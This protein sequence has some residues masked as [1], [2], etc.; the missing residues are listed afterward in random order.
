MIETPSNVVLSG[1]PWAERAWTFQEN[2]FSADRF[3]FAAGRVFYI[4]LGGTRSEH[5]ETLL[6]AGEIQNSELNPT[7]LSWLDSQHGSHDRLDG[8]P[9]VSLDPFVAGEEGR[10][11]SKYL[12]N[13]NIYGKRRA[14]YQ[15][16]SFNAFM[17]ALSYLPAIAQE[18]IQFCWG[19]PKKWFHIVLGWS[20]F[21]YFA[22][23]SLESGNPKHFDDLRRNRCRWTQPPVELDAARSRT[24]FPSWSWASSDYFIPYQCLHIDG[25]KSC[26]IWPWQES[27]TLEHAPD[28]FET[29]ILRIN[30]EC[31]DL[32]AQDVKKQFIVAGTF[33]HKATVSDDLPF[34]E[35]RLT[36]IHICDMALHS[37]DPAVQILGVEETPIKSKV[38]RYIRR[39]C[40]K[41]PLS[42]WVAT[43]TR[44]VTIDLV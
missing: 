39:C 16:D 32:C 23:S 7:A 25:V 43:E 4:C 34:F 27:Y 8:I 41:I 12:K 36:F 40:L 20:S 14:T 42:V 11:L 21:T 18:P 22:P 13:V 30:V 28:P 17:G 26:V 35:D 5:F 38:K 6:K 29:G 9:L 10:V 19:I 37:V 2:Y 33:I 31:A 24:W 1:T 15:S 44:F 3:I